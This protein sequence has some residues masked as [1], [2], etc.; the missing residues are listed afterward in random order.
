M[1]IINYGV[2]GGIKGVSQIHLPKSVGKPS[3]S[4]VILGGVVEIF[5]SVNGTGLGPNFLQ[6]LFWLNFKIK[7]LGRYSNFKIHSLTS[8]ILKPNFWIS[9]QFWLGQNWL[10]VQKVSL[11]I[12]RHKDLKAEV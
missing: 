11:K 2:A 8:K 3:S 12:I 5:Q 4:S 9:F 1:I 10:E 7:I 6:M